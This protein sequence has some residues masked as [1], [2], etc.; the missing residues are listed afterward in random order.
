MINFQICGYL[1]AD[2]QL[3]ERVEN[4]NSETQL[5]E[6]SIYSDQT[7]KEGKDSGIFNMQMWGRKEYPKKI[8]LVLETFKSGALVTCFGR[9][10]QQKFNDKNTGEKRSKNVFIVEKFQLPQKKDNNIT[11]TL[12]SPSSIPF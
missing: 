11:P 1:G 5:V 8:E 3:N 4:S 9:I 10:E 6:F 2:A 12:A 7:T